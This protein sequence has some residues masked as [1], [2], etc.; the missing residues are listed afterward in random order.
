MV[1]VSA[2]VTRRLPSR[3]YL[4][5][6]VLLAWIALW[7]L[8]NGRDTLPLGG[9]QLTP[10]HTRFGEGADV[11]DANRDS[12]PV[13]LYFVNYIRLFIDATVTFVQALI[14]QPSFGR[15]VP[16]VGWLGV[17]GVAT[18]IAY[19]YGNRKVAVLTAAGFVSFGLLGL[20]EESMDTLALTL[21]A[22]A[23]SLAVGIPLGVWAGLSD[24]FNR[25]VTPVLDFMQTMPT[26]V[27]LA[28]LTL[29]F[30]IGPA[31][32]TVATMI[33]AIP[34]AIRLTAHGIRQT[35][36]ATLEAAEALGVTGGQ[37]LRKVRLPLAKQTIVVGINQTIMAALSMATIAALIDA[38]GLGKTV[39]KA[40]QTLD[41]GTAFNAGLAIVIMAIVLD[42]VT[43]AAS[44][45]VEIA[46]RTG[47]SGRRRLRRM[48]TAATAVA[49][50][51]LVYLSYTY[52]WAAEFPAGADLGSYVRRGAD[53]ASGWV[54]ETLVAYTNGLKNAITYALLNP[55]EALLAGSPWWLV[56]VVAVA[57]ALLLA[58]VRASIT[59]AV[60]CVLLVALGLWHDSMV[61]L[62]TTLVATLLVMVLGVVLG[63]WMGRSDRVDRV[64]RPVLDAGQ[65]MPAFVYLV[66]ILGLFGAT[67][68]TA[69][70]AAVVFAAPVSVKLVAEG[71]RG[72]PHT[73][74]EAA[75][76]GGASTWQL[77]SKVQ[78][79]MARAGITLAASQGLI[80]VLSMVV[81]GGLVGAGA[82]G[83]DVVAGFSQYQLRGK[84]LAAGLAIVVLGIVLDRIMRAAAA[85]A[86]GSSATR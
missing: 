52:V 16:L 57:L 6:A 65:T 80:Y 34:P 58:G 21:T 70:I 46:H 26:F 56:A 45:R 53:A 49:A 42:R 78:L 2:P 50:V 17:T 4:T 27:Y 81:V 48:E 11:I 7:V 66:P 25:V 3:S 69:I 30:L 73:A 86:G 12:N 51:V 62:A 35:P 47:R 60:G 68:F 32:A 63:V 5:G 54:Q 38:P 22:V 23:L 31:S 1:A 77:I 79:P 74:V 40:L 61:T 8:L 39:L 19:L 82:L 59:A 76:A 64:L 44:R 24:R 28:P 20:W 43:S 72:V 67:R 36:P 83:Y 75:T 13:F 41:V 84:G 55:F 9:A 33:Y 14:S 10:L 18:A 37:S 85:R 71:I 29:F 15:P